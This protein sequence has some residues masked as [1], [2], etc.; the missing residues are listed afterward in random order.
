MK[1]VDIRNI[2]VCEILKQTETYEK[3]SQST[4]DLLFFK[5][6]SYDWI[7]KKPAQSKFGLFTRTL[8]GYK[9]ILTDTIYP[10]P[11]KR[12]V[13]KYVINPD[14]IEKL[15]KREED[16]CSSLIN[17]H[18]SFYMNTDVIKTLEDRLN[19]KNYDLDFEIAEL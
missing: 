14:N 9:H 16:I 11:S 12:T 19:E 13:N 5:E 6:N 1:T 15:V 4:L 17:K 3:Q 7:Y 8:G 18:K 10:K 2:Y